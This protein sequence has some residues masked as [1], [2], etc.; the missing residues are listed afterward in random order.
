MALFATAIQRGINS[1]EFR[2]VPLEF[3]P[4]IACA[5]VLMLMLWRNSF[6]LCD[7]HQMDAGDYLDAHTD[8]LLHALEATATPAASA[9]GRKTVLRGST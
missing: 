4:R 2:K 6:D 9:A 3:A 7:T 1:G 5:P 8:M